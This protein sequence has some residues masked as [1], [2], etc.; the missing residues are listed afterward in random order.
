MPSLLS[1]LGYCDVPNIAL[2]NGRRCPDLRACLSFKGNH[3]PNLNLTKLPEKPKVIYKVQLTLLSELRAN[4]KK[5]VLMAS[6]N[7]RSVSPGKSDGPVCAR[8]SKF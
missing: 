5:R 3:D 6:S 2:E 7:V 4:R 1:A 8:A